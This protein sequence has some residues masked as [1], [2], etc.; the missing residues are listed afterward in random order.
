LRISATVGS[1]SRLELDILPEIGR[2][3]ALTRRI[4]PVR[5]AIGFHPSGVFAIPNIRV[6]ITVNIR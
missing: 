5:R 4:F 3:L 6:W 1:C 2:K